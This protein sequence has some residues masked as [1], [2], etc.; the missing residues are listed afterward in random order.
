MKKDQYIYKYTKE[1]QSTETD[2]TTENN[3]DTER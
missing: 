2:E 1:P 3:S